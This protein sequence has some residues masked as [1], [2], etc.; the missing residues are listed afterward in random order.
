MI[1]FCASPFQKKQEAGIAR[2]TS[3]YLGLIYL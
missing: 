1:K 3:R 2:R